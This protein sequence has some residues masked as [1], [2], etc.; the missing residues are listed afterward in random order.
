MYTNNFYDINTCANSMS[1]HNIDITI[2]D[3][4]WIWIRSCNKWYQEALNKLK[5][6]PK[7]S[8]LTQSVCRNARNKDKMLIRDFTFIY[9]QV[10]ALVRVGFQSTSYFQK[11]YTNIYTHNYSYV[12]YSHFH[13]I[14]FIKYLY[15][16]NFSYILV[17]KTLD[18]KALKITACLNLK[19]SGPRVQTF[20]IEKD[21]YMDV[22]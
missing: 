4:I 12:K 18:L 19:V 20:S 8:H 10:I 16:G 22:I 1:Q 17:V 2:F 13:I 3:E 14:W 7:K 5:Q 21:S 15:T 9:S 6:T 11:Q